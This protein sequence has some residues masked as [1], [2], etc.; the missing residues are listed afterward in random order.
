MTD[1]YPVQLDVEYPDR[2]LNRLTTFFRAF[3]VIPIAIVLGT[4][5]GAE[6]WSWYDGSGGDRHDQ[7]D[8]RRRRRQPARRP[9]AD[10]RVPPEVPALVV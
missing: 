1:D 8:R 3:T 2:A 4:V 9:A 5:S 10:D 6:A 7:D